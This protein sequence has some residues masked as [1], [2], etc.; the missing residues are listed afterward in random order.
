MRYLLVLF[1]LVPVVV[2]QAEDSKSDWFV[3]QPG[4]DHTAT[5]ATH[6]ADWQTGPAGSKGRVKRRDSALIYDGKPIKFWGLNV[7]YSR[8]C[9]PDKALADKRA[10]FYAKNGVNAVRLHKYADG[11][12]WRGILQES[13]STEFDKGELDRMDYFI[14]ALKKRGIFVKLSPTFGSLSVAAKDYDKI[15]YASEWGARPASGRVLRTNG[16]AIF[17]SSELQDVQIRQTVNLLTHTN[18]YTGMTYAK[19]PAIMLIELVN[20][21]SSLFYGT[22]GQLKKLPTLRKRAGNLFSQWLLKKYGSEDAVVKRWGKGG[23]NSFTDEKMTGESFANN[24]VVPVGSPWYWNPDQI[25]TSQAVKAPRLLDTAEFLCELQTSYYRRYAKAVRKTGYEGELM[26]SNWQA[27]RGS[28]HFYNLYSDR[29]VGLIDRHNYYGG[30]RVSG[31]MMNV[32]GGGLISSGM[33]QVDDRPFCLSEWIHVFPNQWGVEGPAIIGAYGM[34]LQDWDISFMFQNGDDGNYSSKL[35]ASEWDVCAPQIFALFPAIARHVRRGDIASSDETVT[36]NV[37]YDSLRIPRIGFD[38]Q[39]KQAHDIKS[40]NTD[41]VPSEMLL[42]SR[43]AVKFTET[44]EETARV[45]LNTYRRNGA[46]EST[47]QELRWYEGE[48]P[49]GSYFTIDTKA[50]KAVVG[51]AK[52]ISHKLGEVSIKTLS[53]FGALY[54]TSNSKKGTIATDKSLLIVAVAR[55]HNSGMQH[56]AKGRMSSQGKG[57]ILMEPVKAEIEIKRSGNPTVYICDHDGKRTDKTI[58]IKNGSFTIDGARTKTV[59]YEIVY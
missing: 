6:M 43:V 54:V 28:S 32:P 45:N 8:G 50:T 59:Y 23:L 26:G 24:Y 51:F 38:D 21:E 55:A 16:G 17:L 13:S 22:L 27:G 31:S 15:P 56:D 10:D 30:R 52:G 37:H 40:F 20:E 34:G 1:F 2:L 42:V 5:S 11:S 3:W 9:A 53:R 49:N 14:A 35:G 57:P 48:T 4:S 12:G 46:L 19:D 44:Y 29:E 47:T 58:S 7:C 36:M 39:T 33:Q 18:P 25:K 41:R